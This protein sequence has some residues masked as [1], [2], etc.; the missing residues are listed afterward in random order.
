MKKK[1]L[2]WL[3]AVLCCL[4]LGEF[5]REHDFPAGQASSP[6][7]DNLSVEEIPEYAGEAYVK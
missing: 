7:R 4:F 2:I 5:A 3:A 6:G 1:R